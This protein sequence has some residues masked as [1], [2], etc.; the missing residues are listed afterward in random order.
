MACEI[1][2]MWN[3]AAI[4]PLWQGSGNRWLALGVSA[5]VLLGGCG[6]LGFGDP[7]DEPARPAAGEAAGG[8]PLEGEAGDGGVAGAMPSEPGMLQMVALGAPPGSISQYLAELADE[9][10]WEADVRADPFLREA[11]D[12]G[13]Y[14]E[15]VEPRL[16]G[17]FFRKGFSVLPVVGEGHEFTRDT[18]IRGAVSNSRFLVKAAEPIRIIFLDRV[19]NIV[20]IYRKNGRQ[21]Q[22]FNRIAQGS[23]A[24]R[25]SR[26]DYYLN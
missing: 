8:E 4:N 17:L 9:L 6:F 1:A 19:D 13:A 26:L 10:G 3:T 24:L 25:E 22:V 23:V 7:D 18:V 14:D 11:V 20:I 5:L 16:L 2:C 21:P 15:R 12:A